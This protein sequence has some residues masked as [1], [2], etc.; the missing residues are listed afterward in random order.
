MPRKANAERVAQPRYPLNLR[1]NAALHDQLEAA[2]KTS[3]RS[4]TQEATGRLARSFEQDAVFGDPEVRRSAIAMAVA[5]ELAGRWHSD[6]KPG[7]TRNRDAYRAAMFGAIDALLIGMPDMTEH[8][9]ALEIEGLKA[10]F[11]GRILNR[12]LQ[13]QD[14]AEPPL[15]E[16]AA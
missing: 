4:L 11:L 15:R 14:Q 1:M 3:G 13:E 8:E 16:D 7:W 12:R 2:T 5:F 9:I 10:R 6:G